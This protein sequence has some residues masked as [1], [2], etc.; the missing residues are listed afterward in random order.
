MRMKLSA[1]GR[2]APPPVL[3]APFQ[4]L[5][6]KVQ[7]WPGIV[8]ATH[9][10]FSRNGQVDGADFYRGDE[11]LGHIHLDGEIHLA[12]SPAIARVSAGQP[13]PAPDGTASQS[14]CGTTA[15][16]AACRHCARGTARRSRIAGAPE[17]RC[18]AN[19]QRRHAPDQDL[20]P[21]GL[22][23]RELRRRQLRRT[24]RTA[25]VG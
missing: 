4:G 16:P 22:E 12:T 9:W 18:T 19:E 1:K 24:S 6:E 23:R 10:H 25:S 3:N 11:E 15:W 13:R 14:A 5:S 2:H 21:P 17:D 20:V 7:S 8:A